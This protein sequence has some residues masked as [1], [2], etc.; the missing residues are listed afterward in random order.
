MRF[1]RQRK[2]RLRPEQPRWQLS[3]LRFNH[4]HLLPQFPKLRFGG[5]LVSAPRQHLEFATMWI[6]GRLLLPLL[7]VGVLCFYL[8][9]RGLLADESTWTAVPARVQVAQDPLLI[10]K[11]KGMLFV[12]AMTLPRDN[13]PSYQVF[14]NRRKV[15]SANPGRGV[16]LAPGAYEVLIGTGAISQMI[17]K[18]GVQLIEGNTTLMKPDWAALVV[19]VIDEG[20]A[21]I[22][23]SYEL[24]QH[25]S[26]KLVETG[27]GVE[28]ERGERVRT[29]ILKPGIYDVVRVGQSFSTVN[30]YS[31]RLLPGEL[32]QRNLVIDDDSGEFIGFYPRPVQHGAGEEISK[33][34]SQTEISG[35]ALL[36]TSQNTATGDRTSVSLALQVFNRTRYSSDR[37]FASLRIVL[38]EGA[39]KETG[40]DFV[41][42]IDRFEVRA[43]YIYRL[44]PKFGPYLRGVLSTKLFE[45]DRNFDAALEGNFYKLNA[46]GDTLEIIRNPSRVTIEPSFFPLE[47]RQGVG[48]NSQLVRSFP[49]N[50]DIRLG[51]GARQ[52]LVSDAFT[53]SSDSTAVERKTS[54][55]TGIEALLILDS[56]LAKSINFDSEFDI[57]INQTDPGK[58]VFS[59]ENRLRIFLT[60]FINLDLVADLQRQ[61]GLRRI[62][63]REQVLLRF[64]RFF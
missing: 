36:N 8:T 50:V 22:N 9:P 49:L 3:C 24:Y 42:S 45:K 29:W 11:G 58:W 20:R 23:E 62:T 57:L 17:K 38:E 4:P 51:L 28:E 7:L 33:V 14:Q 44:S 55:S 46:Q 47:L 64:S 18:S 21:S 26:Q 1:P 63:G 43:T 6:A 27:F 41:K 59:L 35:S 19:D 15:A 60:S 30:K 53:L 34:S 37:N 10:P 48:I 54:T 61:E 16:L 2:W 31:V 5:P 52:I 12:P 40:Q 25:E 13:E 39:T 32:T 56:R